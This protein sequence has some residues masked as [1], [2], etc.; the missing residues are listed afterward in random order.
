MQTA[1]E[2]GDRID[3]LLD[4][5]A[6]SMSVFKNGEPL[7]VMQESG[8]GGAGVEY[9]WAVGLYN[10]GDSAR[11]DAVPAAEL[12][13]LVQAREA[14]TAQ[15]ERERLAALEKGVFFRAH[16]Q[17]T[18]VEDNAVA[19]LTTNDDYI[20]TAASEATHSGAGL[21]AARFTVRVHGAVSY[22]EGRQMLFGVIRADWDVKGGEFA[23]SVPGHCFYSTYSG[24][25]HCFYDTHD[26]QHFPSHNESLNPTRM[27]NV[28]TDFNATGDGATDDFA[29]IAAAIQAAK[30]GTGA[31]SAAGWLHQPRR[32]RVQGGGRRPRQQRRV[33]HA[34]LQDARDHRG[35]GRARVHGPTGGGGVPRRARLEPPAD[36]ALRH[37]RHRR[38][39]GR[40]RLPQHAVG[41]GEPDGRDVRAVR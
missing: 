8:L 14:L 32:Q 12:E 29:S 11:I 40:P 34:D 38:R 15:R 41:V 28:K 26:G 27:I 19:E 21:H 13:A 36:C 22:P 16:R 24:D 30:A 6:G 31:G 20:P 10:K 35:A 33:Q 17:I 9:R 1:K 4:L 2:E 25:R 18:L 5:G 7:G 3:L 37:R 23:H 39:H